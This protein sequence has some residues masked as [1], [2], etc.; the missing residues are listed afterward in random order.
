MASLCVFK[1]CNDEKPYGCDVIVKMF[2]HDEVDEESV[3]EL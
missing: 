1:R 3:D 2:D